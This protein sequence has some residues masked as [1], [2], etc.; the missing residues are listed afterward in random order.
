MDKLIKLN[1]QLHAEKGLK[2]LLGEELYKQVT[3]AIGDR[4]LAI[5]NDGNW[6]PRAK[7]NTI[8][9]ENKAYKAQVAEL[10]Q[11]LADLKAKIKDN[12]EATKR[13]TALEEELEAKE[14]EMADL[15]KTKQIELEI[16]AAGPKDIKDI[17][18]QIDKSTIKY[19]DGK[20]TGLKE[21]LEE[22]RKNKGY[23][24]NEEAATGTGGSKGNRGK[25]AGG[26]QEITRED[27]L[28]MTYKERAEL[29]ITDRE[30]YDR[31]SK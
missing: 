30:T 6:I 20:I 11:D 8:N 16:L 5:I 22:L 3:E 18:P 2:E 4:E 26:F 27:F 9:E 14:A 12:E 1:L 19:E 15:R 23:L 10:K 31:V 7:F 24:F 13:I 21:Q 17:L 25:T 29:F 28:R